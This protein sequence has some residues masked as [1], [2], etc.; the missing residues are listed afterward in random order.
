MNYFG[1]SDEKVKRIH[2][3][4]ISAINHVAVWSWEKVI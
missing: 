4:L 2:L 3:L 1:E